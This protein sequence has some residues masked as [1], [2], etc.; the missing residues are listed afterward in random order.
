MRFDRNV[1]FT[2]D[3][4]DRKRAAAKRR[5]IREQQALPLLAELVREQQPSI[6]EEMEN[7][8]RRWN[9]TS[10]SH[11]DFEAKVWR[12]ARARLF[13]LPADERKKLREY[14]NNHQWFPGKAVQFAG[15]MNL[16]ERGQLDGF[17]QADRGT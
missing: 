10:Q 9:I 4:T 1:R 6:D 2:F 13:R 15:F 14:W 17:G 11:R 3:V 12:Q 5:Q 16:Y 8:A 7:R